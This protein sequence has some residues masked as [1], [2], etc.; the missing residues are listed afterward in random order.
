MTKKVNWAEMDKRIRGR[1]PSWSKEEA[2]AL[3][4][5]LKKLPDV[6]D[7]AVVIE[8]PQPGVGKTQAADAN[9]EAPN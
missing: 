5:G 6:A 4:S 2:E 9:G 7:K 8:V 3:E 1:R